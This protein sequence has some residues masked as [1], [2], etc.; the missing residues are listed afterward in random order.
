MGRETFTC[1]S[2]VSRS[3]VYPRRKLNLGWNYRTLEQ[4][5]VRYFSRGML[6]AESRKL[7]DI[8]CQAELCQA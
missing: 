4:V 3:E 8:W 2:L 1:G 5:G 6:E 7:E